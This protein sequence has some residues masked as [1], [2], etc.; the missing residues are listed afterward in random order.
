MADRG[1]DVMREYLRLMAAAAL[2]LVA[3]VSAAA[4]TTVAGG[5]SVL[6]GYG[7]TTWGWKDGLL[8]SVIWAISEDQDGYLWLGTEA[9]LVRFDGMRFTPAQEL[10]SGLRRGPV[11]ATLASTD[12]SIWVGY[13]DPDGQVARIR[14]G[15]VRT[16]GP[17]DGLPL[18]QVTLLFEDPHGTIW[19]GNTE[20]L[21][22]LAGDAWIG[23]QPGLPAAAA[24]DAFSDTRGD[25]LVGTAR[26]IFRRQ[27]GDTAF[28]RA[29]PFD[30]VVRNIA[31]DAMGRLWLSDEISA[32][33][34]LNEQKTTAQSL[35]QGRGNRLLYDRRGNLWI[36][37]RAQ[38]LWRARLLPDGKAV[39]TDKTTQITGLSNNGIEALFEDREGNIWVGTSD[40]LN[41]LTP[42][43]VEQVTNLGLV[44]GVE[45]T[46]EG[47]LWLRTADSLVRFGGGRTRSHSD[48][49]AVRGRPLRPMHADDSGNLWV[50][51]DR[52][53][54]RIVHGRSSVVP[55]PHRQYP[56]QIRAL[57]SDAAGRIWLYDQDQGLLRWQPDRVDEMPLPSELQSAQ[58]I[59][60]Y[61]DRGNRIWISFANGQVATI[62][63]QGRVTTH[64]VGGRAA[65]AGAYRT[66]FEADDGVIWLGGTRGLS[67][68]ANGKMVTL[69]LQGR[70]PAG[71][72]TAILADQN[73]RLWLALESAGVVSVKRDE[74]DATFAG[75]TRPLRFRY[76]DRSDGV[77]GT[78]QWFGTRSAVR[79][80]DGRLWFVSGRGVTVVDPKAHA[81][82]ITVAPVRIESVAADGQRVNLTKDS[83]L[84]PRTARIDIDYSALNLSAPSK[85]RFRYRLDGFDADWIDAGYRRQAF[86]TNLPPRSYQFRVVPSLEGGAWADTGAVWTFSIRPTFY[87][88]RWFILVCASGAMLMIAAAWRFRLHQVRGQFTLLL[89]ERAR[90]SRE[91]HDTLLQGMVGVAL[92][93]DVMAND[94]DRSSDHYRQQLVRMR[95]NIEDYIRDARQSIWDLRSV[96]L[97]NTDLATALL[98]GGHHATADHQI[99][100]KLAVTGAVHKCPARVEEQL[101]RIGQEAVT[102]AVRH[103]HPSEVAMTLE[104]ETGRVKLR[105]AD[106]GDGF[107]PVAMAAHSNGHYGLVSMRER[108]EEVGGTFKVES[109]VGRG[110]TIEAIVPTS[111]P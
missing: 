45:M 79:A 20:G 94:V 91:I 2:W 64:G 111:A 48:P 65:P 37:N 15:Q 19:A 63:G 70:L 102:N 62:D 81:D 34:M 61:R 9:G 103:A 90:L 50:A 110:T 31:E 47:D 23:G 75:D 21:F 69:S 109:A 57:T 76:Y 104:Y 41:R 82:S 59:A 99:A 74:L 1:G 55:F 25:L 80:K 67:R 33:R 72:V 32:F 40:G 26:G 30:S 38:G 98:D 78:P 58:V 39:V 14:G 10:G 17:G 28:T 92:Q 53:F 7:L 56:R 24:Y 96:K 88:T 4:T 73:G 36:G 43:K 3:G 46:A 108:A 13:G 95:K 12:G 85:T 27:P 6:T 16:F 60:L 97:E 101:L 52:T 44:S 89:G 86:Y 71:S 107:D 8:S 93:F 68:F 42:H 5:P 87:Q 77:A 18:A 49:M 105:V 106:D 29:E 35:D 100:F 84:P 51:T 11:R 54:L 22:R 66:I 83:V